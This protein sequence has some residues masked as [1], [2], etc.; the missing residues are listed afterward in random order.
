MRLVGWRSIVLAVGLS[1]GVVT[2]TWDYRVYEQVHDQ[3]GDLIFGR[4][5]FKPAFPALERERLLRE[6]KKAPF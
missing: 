5:N 1:A 4:G 6:N 3:V 2:E